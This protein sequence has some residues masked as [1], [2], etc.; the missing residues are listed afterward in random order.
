M[1]KILQ[2]IIVEELGK[3]RRGEVL[4]EGEVLMLAWKKCYEFNM[5]NLDL[6]ELLDLIFGRI[7]GV[8]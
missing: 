7:Y 6:R 4:Y 8:K 3:L 5:L 1:D 2:S